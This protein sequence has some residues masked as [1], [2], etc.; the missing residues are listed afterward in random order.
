MT[1]K[2]G[3]LEGTW[4][5]SPDP[6]TTITLRFVDADRFNWTVSHEGKQQQKMEGT[7]TFGRNILTLAQTQGPALVGN[8]TWQDETHFNFKVPGAAPNDPGLSFSKTN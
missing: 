5:A 2:E 3:R 6:D 8:I 4:T 7:R 1:G